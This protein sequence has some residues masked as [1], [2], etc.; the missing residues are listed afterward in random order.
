M[1]RT[2]CWDSSLVTHVR[3]GIKPI[4]LEEIGAIGGRAEASSAELCS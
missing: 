3:A 4:P 2:D 1:S